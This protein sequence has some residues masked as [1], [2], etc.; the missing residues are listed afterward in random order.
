MTKDKIRENMRKLRR[1]FSG[2]EE[3]SSLIAKKLMSME[4]FILAGH[5]CIYMSAF[6]EVDTKEIIS[7]ELLIIDKATNETIVESFL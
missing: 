1:E 7:G 6:G 4:E 2:K 5:V 3:A